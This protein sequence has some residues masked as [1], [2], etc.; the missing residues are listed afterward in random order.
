MNEAT[1]VKV[2]KPFAADQGRPFAFAASWLYR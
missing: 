1:A 2:S